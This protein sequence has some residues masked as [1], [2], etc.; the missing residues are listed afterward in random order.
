[1]N[2]FFFI[3]STRLSSSLEIPRFQN[4]GYR[5][6]TQVLFSA[7]I[8]DGSWLIK[9]V[10]CKYDENFYFVAS[11]GPDD[12]RIFFLA[13]S[14]D[15]GA[16]ELHLSKLQ[17]YGDFSST[18]PDF[19]SNVAI[20]NIHGGFSSYQAEYPFKMCT[21]RGSLI[22]SVSVLLDPAQRANSIFVRNIYHEPKVEEHSGFLVSK[23]E[24]KV[25]R[26]ITLLS[27]RASVVELLPEEIK[28]D[29]YF[30][31]PKFL[32]IPVYVC[33]GADGSLSMEHTHP[34]HSNVFGDKQFQLV[35]KVK[36]ELIDIIG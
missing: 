12:A 20:Q 13:R 31:A 21:R 30:V 24:K 28:D 11:E 8:H 26:E 33:E 16:D 18:V 19:R 23:K 36:N 14:S 34:P 7:E 10:Y 35:A 17:S 25:I 2:F 29:V 15:V 22:S 4:S 32:G 1:M 9:R 5:D 6:E 27:N 3:T